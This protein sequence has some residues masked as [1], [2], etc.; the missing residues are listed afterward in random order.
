[1]YDIILNRD[2]TGRVA[3]WV[4]ELFVHNITYEPHHAIKSQELAD[5]FIDWEEHQKNPP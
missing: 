4:V 2:A 1:M 3:K 5:F